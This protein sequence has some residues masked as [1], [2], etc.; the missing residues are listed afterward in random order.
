MS[1]A[2]RGL[3]GPVRGNVEG[4]IAPLEDG[5]C[6]RVTIQLDLEGHGIGKLLVPLVVRR[7]AQKELPRNQQKLKERLEASA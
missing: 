7:Q 1:W 2:V 5:A 3:D 6:S 4:T